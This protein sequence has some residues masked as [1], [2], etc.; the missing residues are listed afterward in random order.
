MQVFEFP[1]TINSLRVANMSFDLHNLNTKH[2]L[3]AQIFV[4]EKKNVFGI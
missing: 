1:Q 2:M 3:G 4:G